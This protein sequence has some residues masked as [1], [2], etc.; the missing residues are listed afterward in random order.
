MSNLRYRSEIDGLRAIAVI[1]VV[2]FHLGLGF[3]GG[4]VG[5]DI[6]FVISGFLITSIIKRE[7]EAGTFSMSAF[8]VR[9]IKRILPAVSLMTLVSLT[10]G[11]YLLNSAAFYNL[12]ESSVYQSLL[13][14]N[15]FFSE[16]AGYFATSSDYKPLL[17]TW[18]LSVE[19]QF[20]VIL[21]IT[22]FYLWKWK[23][24]LTPLLLAC[25]AL[26]SFSL[27][28]YGLSESPSETFYLL[29][30][31]AWELLA[32]SLLAYIN[33]HKRWSRLTS[34]IASWVGLLMISTCIFTYDKATPFPGYGALLP[35]IGAVLF[36]GGNQNSLTTAGKLL[37]IRP[38]VW[39][40]LISYSLYLWHWPLLVFAKYIVSDLTCYWKWLILGLSCFTAIL[41]WRF[42]EQ[43]FRS[44]KLL[45]DKK[46]V[47][48]FGVAT[49]ICVL[50]ISFSIWKVEI[51][52]HPSRNPSYQYLSEDIEWS[53][54]PYKLSRKP[55]YI[56]VV[57]GFKKNPQNSP[58]FIIW[59]DSHGMASIE[60][61]NHLAKNEKLLGHSYLFSG[62]SPTI[63]TWRFRDST[64]IKKVEKKLL[65]KTAI[66]N[67][68][69][70]S[71]TKNLIL[72]SRWSV[73]CS[74]SSSSSIVLSNAS[75]K[76][77]SS[78]LVDSVSIQPDNDYSSRILGE[79]LNEM[80][81]KLNTKGIKVWI[82]RQAPESDLQ[83]SAFSF[84]LS[85][86]FPSLNSFPKTQV[87]I[88]THKKRQHFAD[89]ALDSITAEN[90]IILDSS[91]QNFSQSGFLKTHSTTRSYY[92][93]SS[94]LTKA[95][96]QAL[97]T[98]TL[99]PMFKEIKRQ[100]L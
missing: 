60:T 100:S 73:S 50:A 40:G 27:S 26:L 5:V 59:G 54:Q 58:D 9:R 86:R 35:V 24:A 91:P 85:K 75:H 61:F 37:S 30:S 19:E 71:G 42:I 87:T 45:H 69:I 44:P 4:Y 80:C 63:D 49:T 55:P 81:E 1:S 64:D 57:I 68:I 33:I 52:P 99:E 17:H 3:P 38:L 96:A 21:P 12:A 16:D 22:L 8:W 51:K 31:R 84:Y 6:F 11:Y 94:H 83:T 88:E 72:V 25:L 29:P 70:N 34:E 28:C 95:G 53:G 13:S 89:L 56:P 47:F 18:S 66:M 7:I 48:K 46:A 65:R 90:C 15:I 79:S 78:M 39:I 41:S 74:D 20:Y 93:D 67:K 82:L 77:R 23:P 10:L 62:E 76:T 43:P 14:A 36:I 92:R 97:L 98:K 2:F 32:G